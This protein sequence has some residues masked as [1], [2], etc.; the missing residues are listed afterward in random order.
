MESYRKGQDQYTVDAGHKSNGKEL[1][2]LWTVIVTADVEMRN[3]NYWSGL[4]FQKRE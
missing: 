1:C 3:L 2:Y 4:T